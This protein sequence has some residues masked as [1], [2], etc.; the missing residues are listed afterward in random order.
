MYRKIW[1]KTREQLLTI[2]SKKSFRWTFKFLRTFLGKYQNTNIEVQ[3]TVEHQ[4]IV[5]SKQSSVVFKEWE[6]IAEAPKFTKRLTCYVINIPRSTI[7]LAHIIT[8]HSNI[9]VASKSLICDHTNRN[10]AGRH[11]FVQLV[12]IVSFFSMP[13]DVVSKERI[14]E[15]KE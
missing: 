13:F 8:Q 4:R 7:F 6:K 11:E 10:F 5:F 2:D 12:P 3:L 14:N 9:S 15:N 1:N